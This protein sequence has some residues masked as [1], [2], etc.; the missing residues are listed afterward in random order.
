MADTNNSELTYAV[1]TGFTG[2][3]P[4]TPDW[5]IVERSEISSF[6]NTFTKSEP[7]RIS[8]NRNMRKKK[9]QSVDS[10]VEFTAPLDFDS[11]LQFSQ[12]FVMGLAAGPSYFVSTAATGTGVTVPAIPAGSAS[13]M[14]NGQTIIGIK[15]FKT[16][17]NNG[18]RILG[19]AVAGGATSITLPNMTVESV[20][21]NRRAE[22]YIAGVRGASGDLQI[23]ADQNLTSTALDLSALGLVVGQFIYIG[24]VDDVNSFNEDENKGFAQITAIATNKLTLAKRDQPYT[25]ETGA[26]IS[27]D[28]LFGP[29]IRNYSVDHANFLR[30]YYMFGL[31]TVFENGNPTIH[32]YALD[33]ACDALSLDV[34]KDGFVEVSF[35]FIGSITNNPSTTQAAGES[36]AAPYNAT[37]EYS[38]STDLIRLSIDD[39]DESGLMTDFDSLSLTISN[40]ISAR[41]VLGQI[42][43]AQLNLSD[44][45]V[46]TEATALFTDGDVIE[47]IRCDKPVSLRL[48]FWNDDGGIY[49]HV[50]QM[51]LEGGDR[52]WPENESVTINSTGSAF[53]DDIDGTSIEISMFPVLPPRPC[54]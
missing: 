24:G 20:A 10:T 3:L 8:R 29:Y 4:A 43:A 54:S 37:Q 2:T 42:K 45:A 47:R 26:G 5:R 36:D 39:I 12:G 38:T 19:G 32:E 50:P 31:K 35:G 6:G 22:I 52:A 41:K 17:S 13:Q 11:T 34:Q 7:T 23:D 9:T 25:A 21:S 40:G 28:I 48:P 33:N 49:F 1:Q 16:Q 14:I 30:R 44:L 15:G 51:T 46:T 53:H 27:V 18:H